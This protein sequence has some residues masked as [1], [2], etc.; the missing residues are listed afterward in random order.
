[1]ASVQAAVL[2]SP[3]PDHHSS[4]IGMREIIEVTPEVGSVDGAGSSI[5]SYLRSDRSSYV[6]E[7][8]D[9]RLVFYM[10]GY[11]LG[12][13]RSKSAGDL[14]ASALTVGKEAA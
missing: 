3:V 2:T 10:A 11:V 12:K 4:T 6:V 13:F 9:C 14:C 7:V 1:M 5:K 8:S